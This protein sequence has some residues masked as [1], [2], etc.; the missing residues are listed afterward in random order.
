MKSAYFW[1]FRTWYPAAH[2]WAYNWKVECFQSLAALIYWYWGAAVHSSATVLVFRF[3]CA[4]L[5]CCCAGL[6][7]RVYDSLLRG[8]HQKCVNMPWAWQKMLETKK[9]VASVGISFMWPFCNS[10]MHMYAYVCFAFRKKGKK[11]EAP[12]YPKC[13]KLL[14]SVTSGHTPAYLWNFVYNL[15]ICEIQT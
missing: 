13:K 9:T 8:K 5:T 12:L 11:P 7:L 10:W 1:T 15:T 14:A 4:A 6:Q 2:T 3:I